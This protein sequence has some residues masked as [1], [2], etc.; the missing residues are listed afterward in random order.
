MRRSYRPLFVAS[1]SFCL[2]ATAAAAEGP[3]PVITV[4]IDESQLVTL[5]GNTPPAALRAGNDRGAVADDLRFDHLLLA[6]KGA[7]ESEARLKNL[8]YELHN[9]D[10]PEYH[11]WLA[12]EQLGAEF[13]LAPQD[14]DILTHWLES[15]GFT[16]NRVYQ[17]GLVIDFAGTGG[18]IREA[19]HTEIHSLVLP[20]GEKHLANIRDPQIP[21]AL[22][23]A[24]EGVASLHDF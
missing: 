5:S 20:S 24:I 8:I 18:Q 12:P 9:P 3:K 19:F 13:G 22:A 1:L 23:T 11:Q 2:F 10:S 7:P 14:L 15:H 4:P 16:I 6:R 21:A 17:N